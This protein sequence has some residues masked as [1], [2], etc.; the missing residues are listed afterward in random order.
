M[1]RG[2]AGRERFG[3]GEGEAVVA[4]SV[5]CERARSTARLCG[6]GVGRTSA[7]FFRL[8]F[9]EGVERAVVQAARGR[10]ERSGGELWSLQPQENPTQQGERRR[11]GGRLA[12][13]SFSAA[14]PGKSQ[15]QRRVR[16]T[17]GS[18]PH[19]TACRRRRELPSESRVQAVC[20]P[21]HA[22]S[23][24]RSPSSRSRQVFPRWL[25]RQVRAGVTLLSLLRAGARP[26]TRIP[27]SLCERLL[28]STQDPP[29]LPSPSPP[30]VPLRCL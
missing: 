22:A 29:L 8:V 15:P 23:S 10:G 16:A 24:S 28:L 6:Q 12:D 25:A 3:G 19:G 21:G 4:P 14:G 11:R 7:I 26:R 30:P 18:T 2:G 13:A 27:L 17:K 1:G 5:D 9:W 20:R